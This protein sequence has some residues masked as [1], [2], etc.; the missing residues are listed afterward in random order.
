MGVIGRRTSAGRAARRWHRALAADAFFA[1]YPDNLNHRY[2]TCCLFGGVWGLPWR[3]GYA[4][5]SSSK[6]LPVLHWSTQRPWRT[7]TLAFHEP[8]PPLADVAH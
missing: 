2:A 6:S 4:G 1:L 5:E 7:P 3:V 8:L